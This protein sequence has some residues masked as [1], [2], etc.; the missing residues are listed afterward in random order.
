MNILLVA[1][2]SISEPISGAER[3]LFEQSTRLSNREH[4]VYILTRKLQDHKSNQEVTQGVREWRYDVDQ[5]NG[6]SFIKST[7]INCRRLFESLQN[8]FSF[9]C[10]NFHQ[11]FSARG[12]IRS[13][14]S[15]KVK[16]IYTCHSL[17]FEEFQSRNPR[18][19]NIT[20]KLSYSFN[21]QARRFIERKIL[22]ESDRIA[23]LSRFTQKK[24]W[25]A[26]KVPPGKIVIIPGGV[27]LERFYPAVDKVEIRRH[28]K[29]PEERMILFTVRDLEPRM[30][31]ENLI[32]L[33]KR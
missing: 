21:I 26:Y 32:L 31:L 1:D 7:L 15:K 24:L 3:V 10:I 9:D 33:S 18:P 20:K 6:L 25:S 23:V 22:N 13:P 19:K 17:S 4:D 27:D 30:G 5:R 8:Q 14:A 28:L 29:I 16:K 2:V 11:P 12:V